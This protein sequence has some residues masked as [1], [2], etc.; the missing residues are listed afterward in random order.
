VNHSS[1]K[2]YPANGCDPRVSICKGI[3]FKLVKGGDFY[4]PFSFKVITIHP[5]I[6]NNSMMDV[7]IN[8]IE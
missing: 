1:D 2:N 3:T 6:A 4:V 7:S 5:T 8:H